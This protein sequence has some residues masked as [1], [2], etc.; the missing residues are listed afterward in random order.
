LGVGGHAAKPH[1]T[2]DPTPVAA[3]IVLALQTIVSRT[4]DPLKSLVVSVTSSRT[5]TDAHNVISER[6][7]LRGT[8][9]SFDRELRDKAKERLHTIAIHTAIAHGATAEVT[10][11]D[12]YPAM[13]N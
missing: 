4:A 1:L 2:I 10:W 6:V 7:Q 13:I 12:G 11:V 8:V 5:D 3:H 9:R